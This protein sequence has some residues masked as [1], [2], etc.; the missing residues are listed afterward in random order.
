MLIFHLLSHSLQTHARTYISYPWRKTK[1]TVHKVC[2]QNFSTSATITDGSKRH[3]EAYRLATRW[4]ERNGEPQGDPLLDFDMASKRHWFVRIDRK[5]DRLSCWVGERINTLLAFNA[6]MMAMLLLLSVLLSL[7]TNNNTRTHTCN[8]NVSRKLFHFGKV[9]RQVERNSECIQT[10][11]N[12]SHNNVKSHNVIT[13]RRHHRLCR[14]HRHFTFSIGNPAFIDYYC[15][16]IIALSIHRWS[17]HI[18]SVC[19]FT[20]LF[21]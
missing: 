19:I 5:I 6:K 20:N 9:A 10:R 14:P 15:L 8:S 17:D 12:L 11:E 1:C 16:W 4:N 7:T 18:I 2:R 21:C 3:C 13:E